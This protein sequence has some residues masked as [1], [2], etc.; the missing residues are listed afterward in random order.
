MQFKVLLLD[1]SV[2]FCDFLSDFLSNRSCSVQTADSIGSAKAKIAEGKYNLFL[3]DLHLADGNGMDLVPRI[4]MKAIEFI[5]NKL[6][7][8]KQCTRR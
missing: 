4:R 3:F 8:K 1:D 5:K 7:E 2:S 6:R